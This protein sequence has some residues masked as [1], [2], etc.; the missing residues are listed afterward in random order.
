M[1]GLS[2]VSSA[3]RARRLGGLRPRSR[4]RGAR[5]RRSAGSD[6]PP[7]RRPSRR[8]RRSRRGARPG[9]GPNRR[10]TGRTHPPAPPSGGARRRR[11][12]RRSPTR[13]SLR[14]SGSRS[15]GSHRC[16]ASPR[17]RL[18]YPPS[19][20]RRRRAA[21]TPRPPA[22]RAPFCSPSPDRESAGARSHE[23]PAGG[24]G[25]W[26]AGSRCHSRRSRWRCGPRS[27]SRRCRP[28]GL[29]RAGS[30]GHARRSRGWRRA[31]RGGRA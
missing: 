26:R 28:S 15:P 27:R 30:T 1:R 20:G 10:A 23:S 22:R 7:A 18:R 25:P 5:E 17:P 19:I 9:R 2:S 11:N 21:R 3:C 29:S 16:P 6:S 31:G 13:R 4:T 12:C 14:G 8:H 24:R